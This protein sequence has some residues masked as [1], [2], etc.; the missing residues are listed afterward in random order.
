MTNTS[1]GRRTLRAEQKLLTRRRLLDAATE[2]FHKRGFV[3]ATVDD[4]VNAAEVSRATFYLHYA[5]KE[6]ILEEISANYLPEYV[7]KFEQ[8][9]DTARNPSEMRQWMTGMVAFLRGHRGHLAAITEAALAGEAFVAQQRAD[10]VDA[11]PRVD[12]ELRGHQR[13]QRRRAGTSRAARVPIAFADGV[14]LA[15]IRRAARR[16][17]G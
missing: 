15:T 7:A 14:R 6:A 5:N 13:C 11:H 8:F 9:D 12:A 4:I 3:A 16:H 1:P 2:V 17:L 10:T